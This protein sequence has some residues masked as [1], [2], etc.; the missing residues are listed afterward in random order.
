MVWNTCDPT[1]AKIPSPANAAPSSCFH[2][3]IKGNA[4]FQLKA[5]ENKTTAFPPP[6]SPMHREESLLWAPG[7]QPPRGSRVGTERTHASSELGTSWAARMSERIS[8]FCFLSLTVLLKKTKQN[9]KQS[10]RGQHFRGDH[11]LQAIYLST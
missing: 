2:S 7:E 8:A 3:R 5:G 6:T 11:F 10:A 4:T 1:G 9:K